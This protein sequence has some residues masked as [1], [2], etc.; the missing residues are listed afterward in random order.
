MAILEREQEEERRRLEEEHRKTEEEQE[1]VEEE[2]R[3]AMQDTDVSSG[4]G[5]CVQSIGDLRDST[6]NS[7]F[8]LRFHSVKFCI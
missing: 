8:C 1:R 4:G 7:Q 2:I 6:C 5:L 3:S